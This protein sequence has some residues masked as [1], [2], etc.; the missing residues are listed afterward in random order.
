MSGT[1]QRSP[2]PAVTA[3]FRSTRWKLLLAADAVTAI[4]GAIGYSL[5]KN[6]LA[7]APF[8]A[9]AAI[10]IVTLYRLIK[11]GAATSGAA[12]HSIVK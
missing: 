1:P 8:A 11:R 9:V 12:D 3:F 5:T 7:F 2:N 6:L 4:G 10:L